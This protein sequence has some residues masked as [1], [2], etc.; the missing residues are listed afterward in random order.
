M[1]A[2]HFGQPG[3]EQFYPLADQSAIRFQLG[4]TGTAQADAAFLS[5]QVSPATHQTG[6]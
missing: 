1:L 3:F 4:F 6:G 2:L 5:F